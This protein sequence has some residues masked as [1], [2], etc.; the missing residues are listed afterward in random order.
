MPVHRLAG[1]QR[2]RVHGRGGERRRGGEGWVREVEHVEQGVGVGV[3]GG[4][5]GDAEARF[6]EAEDRGV[7]VN[8]LKY[9]YL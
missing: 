7:A 2:V 6:D 8:K 3:A 1:R 4:E 5:G 9:Q